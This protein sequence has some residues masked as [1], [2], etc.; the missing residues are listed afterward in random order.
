V[1]VFGLIQCS[2]QV[3]TFGKECITDEKHLYQY[4]GCVG[5]P[6]L[7]IVDDLLSVTECGL[8]SVKAYG[9]LNAKTDIKKLQF[10]GDKCKK[11]H[12]S[13]KKH[14]CP[15]CMLTPGYLIRRMKI[16]KE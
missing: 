13:K 1:E 16:R 11:L 5:V 2:V 15:D 9:F 14:L 4:R 10:G 8:E 6:P 7:A 3:D 12:I